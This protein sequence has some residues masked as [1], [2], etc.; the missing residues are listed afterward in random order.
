[1]SRLAVYVAN[2]EGDSQQQSGISVDKGQ[3]KYPD[4]VRESESVGSDG[5]GENF[6]LVVMLR[7]FFFSTI[8]TDEKLRGS[9]RTGQLPCASSTFASGLRS[10]HFNHSRSILAGSS[11]NRLSSV[12]EIRP[13][14]S[15]MA[16]RLFL[17]T[18]GYDVGIW[19]WNSL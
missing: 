19:S 8:M 4:E 16:Q 11:C 7:L 13:P 9:H 17:R 18:G 5:P 1:M 6:Y 10:E 2:A 3:I 15:F 14:S 12:S